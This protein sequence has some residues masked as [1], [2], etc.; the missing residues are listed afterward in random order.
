MTQWLERFSSQSIIHLAIGLVVATLLTQS[1]AAAAF[2][3][4]QQWRSH[5]GLVV[6]VGDPYVDVYVQPG[7]GY[8]RFHVVEKNQRMRIF[9]RRPGWYKVE[10]ED[11]KIGW[12][13]QKDL[14]LVYDTNGYLIDFSVPRWDE[15]TNPLQ[16]GVLAGSM[17]DAV[18]YTVFAGYRFTPNISTEIR[19]S[20]GFSDF[21]NSKLASINVLHQPFPQ[22][23]YSPFFTL[24]AG[25]IR[26]FPDSV[27]VDPEDQ[28]DNIVSVGG[29]LMIYLSYKLVARLEYNKHT[30]LT[31]RDNNQE[32]EEWKAGLSVLF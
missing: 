24:G 5:K 12:V 27:L 31:T 21:S 17:S 7:R 6:V 19:Y 16:L 3:G 30:M 26:T 25:A 9:K 20:Q 1:A 22:W 13:K 18:A 4:A 15:V 32:V 10:T 2:D 8:A 29:G 28:Q 14:H 11:G 23:R